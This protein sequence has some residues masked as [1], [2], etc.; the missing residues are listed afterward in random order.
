MPEDPEDYEIGFGKPPKHTQFKKGQ[1]GNPKGRPKGSKSLAA[2]FDELARE[3]MW[4][5]TPNGRKRMSWFD[6]NI[7]QLLTRGAKGDIRA[8]RQVI[9]MRK[10]IGEVIPPLPPLIRE[11]RFV[12][13]K[14]R[15]VEVPWIEPPKE[16]IPDPE[17][18]PIP[19]QEI[20]EDDDEYVEVEDE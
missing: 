16:R 14:Y 1:S 18:E 15:D 20:D 17:K 11:I 7:M 12:K 2:T 9:Q 5:N 4:V 10:E 19:D 3:K 6:M 8:I 13:S